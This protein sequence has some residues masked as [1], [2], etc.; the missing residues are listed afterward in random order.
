MR[1]GLLGG[2]FDPIHLGHVKLALAALADGL[3][4]VWLVVA[5]QAPLKAQCQVDFSH[6]CA[7]VKL[8]LQDYPGLSVCEIEARLPTPSYTIHTVQA[9]KQEY[10]AVDFVYL[11]GQDQFLQLDQWHEIDQLK[12]LVE[13]KVFNR[14]ADNPTLFPESSTAIRNGRLDYLDPKVLHYM[15][16][17]HLYLETW[18]AKQMSPKR[19]AHVMGCVE[20]ALAI[21]ANYDMEADQVYLAALLHD[22][23]KELPKEQLFNYLQPEQH[24]QPKAVWHQYAGAKIVQQEMH[25]SDPLIYEAIATHTTGDCTSQLAKVIFCA[26]KIEPTRP[27]DST[28]LVQLAINDLDEAFI[29]IK[30][31]HHYHHLKE[32]RHDL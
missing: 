8:A 28:H 30:Q 18:V 21:A 16:I 22:I 24:Q 29:T 27:Y 10:P 4:E 26:D 20:C 9:L 31:L 6:R 19:F 3:D 25:L 11:I 15:I 2:S 32:P 17:N 1:I 7:M 14:Q 5:N 13:F 12:Q 23:A